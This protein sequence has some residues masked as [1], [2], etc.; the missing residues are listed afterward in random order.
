MTMIKPHSMV[1]LL[2]RQEQA[3]RAVGDD[4]IA[5]PC[6]PGSSI[7]KGLMQKQCLDA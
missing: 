1:K 7:K 4:N 2:R 5:N 3:L 6:K